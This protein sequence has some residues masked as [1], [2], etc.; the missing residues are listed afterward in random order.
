MFD[1][2]LSRAENL[3]SANYHSNLADASRI[4]STGN[5]ILSKGAAQG[6]LYS[7]TTFDTD[8]N[9][10]FRASEHLWKTD[11]L[12]APIQ[13]SFLFGEKGVV[14]GS[15]VPSLKA[16]PALPKPEDYIE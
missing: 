15:T 14:F 16:A 6:N 12:S 9:G 2:I 11:A 1:D 5:S 7:G 4:K 8:L 10:I 13:K 3:S